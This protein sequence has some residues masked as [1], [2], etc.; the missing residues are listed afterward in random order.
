M[1]GTL[2]VQGKKFQ[3]GGV[4]KSIRYHKVIKNLVN[5]NCLLD[6]LRSQ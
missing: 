6:W 5:K 2:K 3:E 1:D 4:V